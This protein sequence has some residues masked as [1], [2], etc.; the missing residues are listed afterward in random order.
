MYPQTREGEF[1]SLSNMHFS[2]IIN[3]SKDWDGKSPYIADNE[4]FMNTDLTEN[5]IVARQINCAKIIDRLIMKALAPE[6][7]KAGSY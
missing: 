7:K 2:D 4:L 1:I 5:D 6:N 3:K